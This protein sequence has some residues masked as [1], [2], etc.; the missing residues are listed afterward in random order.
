[1]LKKGLHSKF[2]FQIFCTGSIV[3][4]FLD[5]YEVFNIPLTWIGNGLIFIIFLYI[6]ILEKVKTNQAIVIITITALIPTLINLFGRDYDLQYL[7]L[8]VFSFLTFVLVMN[9]ITKTKRLSSIL[10]SLE[11][12]YIFIGC[13][14]IY[15][16][17]SQI[18]NFYEPLRN[19]PGT[20]ILGYD[21]QSNFWISGSHRMVGTFRE[22]IFL[23]SILFPAF[24]ILHYKIGGSKFFYL[25]SGV[26]SGLTK[27]EL[28][29]VYVVLFFVIDFSINKIN[30]KVV[31]F[32]TLFLITFFLPIKECDISPS[33]IECPEIE[34]NI[35]TVI[36]EDNTEIEIISNLDTSKKSSAV[37]FED[38]ERS[39][40][41]SFST[42][43][44]KF[45]TGAG[46]QNINNIYSSYLSTQ[47]EHENYLVNRTSPKY[48]QTKYLSKSFGTGRYFLIY[49]DINLQNNFLFNLFS[50][51]PM[52]G[53]L[54]F[55]VILALI[56]QNI[57]K[58]INTTLL[59]LIISLSSFEDLLPIFGLYLGLMIAKDENEVK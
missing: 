57:K 53:I 50:I 30:R 43:F 10:I 54:L 2:I 52:Y 1:M 23:V 38:R 49:E 35:D 22:P 32:V 20:G 37:E 29:L 59:I 13:F 44:V 3:L 26:I 21:I 33:N 51:G 5:S 11:K 56:N 6:V 47:I 12:A 4:I 46:F 34:T 19:R 18:F 7:I 27:S 48:L 31:Y 45:G 16:F 55:L 17:I 24:L 39:D 9:V 41:F 58:G 36:I 40:I 25:L 14:S 28:A 8:R 42:Y 15:A